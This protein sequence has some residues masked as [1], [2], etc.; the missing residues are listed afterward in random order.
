M[1]AIGSLVPTKI[2]NKTLDEVKHIPS[3]IGN[4]FLEE[5][6]LTL[7]FNPSNRVVYLEY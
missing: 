3:I 1:P 5:Q 6:K 4:E 2:D 7:Y